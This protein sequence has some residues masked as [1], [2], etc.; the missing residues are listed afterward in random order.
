M[1]IQNL[2]EYFEIPIK[3]AI[4][5][6][7]H[8]AEEKTWYN[9]NQI[10]SVIW[11]EA[12]PSYEEKIKQIVGDDIVI[13]SGVGKEKGKFKF[14]ISNNGQSSSLLELDLHRRHHPDVV[15]VD[16][17]EIEVNKM[18]DIIENYNI[19]MNQYNFLNLDIQGS[20]LDALFGFESYLNKIDYIY[21]E[22]NTNFLYRDCA[23]IGDIDEYLKK[24]SFERVRTEITHWEWG[25]AF[26][27]K[28]NQ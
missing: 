27:V 20:E 14:N 2:K 13:I 18:S 19:D 6:G 24:Y 16:S 4:H 12:N 9:S 21:T 10:T 1:L 17:I 15:Y 22:V 5:I 7:A 28:K 23:L 8:M 3:G 26:Y 11:I 25:D